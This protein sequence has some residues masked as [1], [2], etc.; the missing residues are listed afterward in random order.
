[1]SLSTEGK[2]CTLRATLRSGVWSVTRDD[3]FYGD[4]LSRA[5][6]VR[7]ACLATR[8]FEARGGVARVFAAP[9]ETLIPHH[10]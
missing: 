7:Q 4:F 1:M 6:A 9:G 10:R 3:V 5:E 8:A 2:T